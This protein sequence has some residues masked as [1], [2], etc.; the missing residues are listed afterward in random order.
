[1]HTLNNCAFSVLQITNKKLKGV[2]AI[3]AVF[4]QLS[5]HNRA[6]DKKKQLQK[7]RGNI[8]SA[9]RLC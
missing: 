6:E 5:P 8:I 9:K 4:P 3:K 2:I 1:M 7:P